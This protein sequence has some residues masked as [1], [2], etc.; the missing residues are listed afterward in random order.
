[1]R[2]GFP[3][4]L[5][6]NLFIRG[7]SGTG[8]FCL[9]ERSN[10]LL[11]R[12]GVCV[13]YRSRNRKNQNFSGFQACFFPPLYGTANPDSKSP[14]AISPHFVSTLASRRKYL[15]LRISRNHTTLPGGAISAV[16]ALALCANAFISGRLSRNSGVSSDA[17]G[18]LTADNRGKRG[19]I[20]D[21]RIA[22]NDPHHHGQNVVLNNMASPGRHKPGASVPGRT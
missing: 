15:S 10:E 16:K 6:S 4:S 21:K 1:M 8:G 11:Y 17:H 22:V 5:F 19:N 3:P 12:S 7:I 9:K 2:K 14:P 20:H 18:Y 13:H